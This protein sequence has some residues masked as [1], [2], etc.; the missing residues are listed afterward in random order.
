MYKHT[1]IH[2]CART[3][4]RT[5]FGSYARLQVVAL[6]KHIFALQS[7][8][9]D[10]L[11]QSMPERVQSCWRTSL[12]TFE[13]VPVTFKI[14]TKKTCVGAYVHN[15]RLNKL[16]LRPFLHWHCSF[17]QR[18]AAR[19]V[20]KR[21]F[22]RS[23]SLKQSSPTTC[24]EILRQSVKWIIILKPVYLSTMWEWLKP[25]LLSL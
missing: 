19:Q 7:S 25:K 14:N 23:S 18:F 4:V 16:Y 6:C 21:Q 5:C 12:L 15:A 2:I 10:S 20:V 11:S 24:D 9:W 8:N 1:Y 3:Y 13:S 17:I 22:T